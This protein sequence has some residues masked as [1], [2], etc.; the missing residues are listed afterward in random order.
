MVIEFRP[1]IHYEHQTLSGADGRE[2]KENKDA[3][4]EWKE[5]DTQTRA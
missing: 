4:L 5:K 3:L 1:K 2:K